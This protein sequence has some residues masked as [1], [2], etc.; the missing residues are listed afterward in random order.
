MSF[1]SFSSKIKLSYS[2][3]VLDEEFT[4]KII[5]KSFCN[6]RVY[7]LSY[8]VNPS[9]YLSSFE[10]TFK[11]IALAGR[12]KDLH[13]EINIQLA[14]KVESCDSPL[15]QLPNEPL[16]L[17]DRQTRLTSIGNNLNSLYS[18]LNKKFISARERAIYLAGVINENMRYKKGVTNNLTTAEEAYSLKEGVC[19]DYSHILIA[20]LRRDGIKARYVAGLLEG[21][22]ESH[23]WVEVLDNGYWYTIDPVNLESNK[24]HLKIAIGQDSSDTLI[25]RGIYR[26]GGSCSMEACYTL[27]RI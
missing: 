1:Y 26:G 22:G 8:S 24:Y 11:N 18:T 14:G 2:Q 25:N 4:L 6:Q 20:L 5:P 15:K 23:G 12:V 19:Q 16:F 27:K 10:D 17:Y 9:D 3:C 13:T 7:D 21:V